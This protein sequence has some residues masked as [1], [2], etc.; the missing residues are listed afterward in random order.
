MDQTLRQIINEL[1]I[2]SQQFVLAQQEIERLK[3]A[4]NAAEARDKSE[5]GRSQHQKRNEGR[6][7]PQTSNSD[8]N[9]D[10]N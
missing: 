6:E 1:V 7:A 8:S 10:S 3:E 2:T 5:N 9:S 4:L